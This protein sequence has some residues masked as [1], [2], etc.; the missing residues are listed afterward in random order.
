MEDTLR[1]QI[2]MFADIMA[3]QF[4][5]Q[6]TKTKKREITYEV[7]LQDKFHQLPEISEQ[8]IY[9]ELEGNNSQ[10]RI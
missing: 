6:R 9:K 7:H 2:H 10:A 4:Q 5:R 1:K 3:K 8:N